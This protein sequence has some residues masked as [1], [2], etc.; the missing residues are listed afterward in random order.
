MGV[1][2]GRRSGGLK[3]MRRATEMVQICAMPKR[4]DAL[5]HLLPKIFG[6]V[7]ERGGGGPFV[8]DAEAIVENQLHVRAQWINRNLIRASVKYRYSRAPGAHVFSVIVAPEA[9]LADPDKFR[10]HQG[11]CRIG[12]WSRGRWED[13][14]GSLPVKPVPVF[15]L[16][17]RAR[18][19]WRMNERLAALI[20][21]QVGPGESE[22][23]VLINRVLDTLT[24]PKDLPH[25]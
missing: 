2:Q 1:S 20:L 5:A 16:L 7:R 3:G 6:V 13:Q 21:D 15:A 25:D 14:I 12:K 19:R 22:L 11:R 24:P 18:R 23:D 4:D 9:A 8:E 17:E 10:N